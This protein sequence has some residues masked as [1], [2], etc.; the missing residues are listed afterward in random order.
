MA[1]SQSRNLSFPSVTRRRRSS[2]SS[3]C[4]A[5][6]G[7]WAGCFE[8]SAQS[9]SIASNFSASVIF[10]SGRSIDME[11]TFVSE[12]ARVIVFHGSISSCILFA[13]RLKMRLFLA[14]CE[15]ASGGMGPP[16]HGYHVL[17]LQWELLSSP[18]PDA[19]GS[20][21]SSRSQVVRLYDEEAGKRVEDPDNQNSTARPIWPRLQ[22]QATSG[23]PAL[24]RQ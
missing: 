12:S 14:S 11:R 22:E 6:E 3:L 17:G 8:M 4:H 7:N 10:S 13:D 15:L 18:S 24:A 5:G 19:T 16:R 2:R 21:V 20:P 23:K 9:S 1:V